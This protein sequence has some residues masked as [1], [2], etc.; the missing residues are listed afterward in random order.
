MKQYIPKPTRC[1]QCNRF[2]HVLSH[3]KGKESCSKCGVEHNYALCM[4][5]GSKWPNCK[6]NHSANDRLC[7]RYKCE[8][9]VLKKIRKQYHVCRVEDVKQYHGHISNT[10]FPQVPSRS[11]FPPLIPDRISGQIHCHR[12]HPCKDAHAVLHS[13]E[14]IVVIEQINSLNMFNNSVHFLAFFADVIQQTILVTKCKLVLH[15]TQNSLDYSLHNGFDN[16]A[17]KFWI[18]FQEVALIEKYISELNN[19]PDVICIQE[20]HIQ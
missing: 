10:Q 5:T 18:S 15:Q 11:E 17:M 2:G 7:P 9:K 12:P 4:A 19:Q 3:C 20:T 6:G 16:H 14:E 1:F 8:E 13:N